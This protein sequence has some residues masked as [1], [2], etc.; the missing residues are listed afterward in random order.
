M[1]TTIISSDYFNAFYEDGILKHQSKPDYLDAETLFTIFPGSEMYG[2]PYDLYDELIG[3]QDGY[4]QN[5]ED[6]DLS[7]CERYR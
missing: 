4:P 3:Q 2:V 6:F 7:R 1:K 5:L